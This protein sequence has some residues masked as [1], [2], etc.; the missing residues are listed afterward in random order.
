MLLPFTQACHGS[1]ADFISTREASPG[2]SYGTTVGT[3]VKTISQVAHGN[4]SILP[5]PRFIS[6]KNHSEIYWS[7]NTE[8]LIAASHTL[9]P[10]C[11]YYI[12]I[13]TE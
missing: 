6:S 7:H 1:D 11:T 2:S 3:A 8:Y 10:S 5:G 12:Q 13:P 9:V 4:L